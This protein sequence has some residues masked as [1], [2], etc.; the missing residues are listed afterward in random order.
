MIRVERNFGQAVAVTIGTSAF[1]PTTEK[2]GLPRPPSCS[3]IE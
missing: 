3:L 1:I 2:D